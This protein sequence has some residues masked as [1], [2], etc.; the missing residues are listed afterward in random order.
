MAIGARFP[1]VLSAAADGADWAW[2]E[3]YRDLAPG[4][5]RFLRG[6]GAAD[7]ED[8][9]GDCL[10]QV[11]R[12]LHTFSGEEAD[13]RTWVFRIARTRLIDAWRRDQRRPARAGEDVTTASDRLRHGSAADS[14]AVERAGIE[15]ILSVLTADQRT[16]LLLRYL[17]QFTPA[18]IAAVIDKGEGAVRVLQHRALRTLRRSLP[19][20]AAAEFLTPAD[21]SSLLPAG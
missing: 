6:Q 4:L 16:V 13:F 15:E 17:H 5:L 9:L 11:V 12:S 14:G 1:Q 10:L 20:Q 2:A 7:P 8:C 3:L 19:A 18:E 21:A